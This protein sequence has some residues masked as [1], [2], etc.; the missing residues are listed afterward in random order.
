MVPLRAAL[1]LPLGRLR[2]ELPQLT[3]RDGSQEV[4]CFNPVDPGGD[5]LASRRR[6]RERPGRSDARPTGG[7]VWF[8]I[9][10]GLVLDRHV[11]DVKAVDGVTMSIQRGETVG[12]V[13]ESGCGKS[14]LGRAISG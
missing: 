4:A 13:G 14:T 7:R 5:R 10:S 9:K 11:G 2:A 12:L 6:V 3:R 8:P 1:Q